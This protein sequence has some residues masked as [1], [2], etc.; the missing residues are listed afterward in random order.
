MYCNAV[1][2]SAR[3]LLTPPQAASSIRVHLKIITLPQN[4]FSS[5]FS[6]FLEAPVVQKLL[7]LAKPKPRILSNLGLYLEEPHIFHVIQC[8]FIEHKGYIS[9]ED[10]PILVFPSLVLSSLHELW[11]PNKFQSSSVFF[12]QRVHK[13]VPLLHRNQT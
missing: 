8:C 9:P 11:L 6:P 10:V 12:L 7:H 5:S 13:P 4:I 3:T 1:S 2:A